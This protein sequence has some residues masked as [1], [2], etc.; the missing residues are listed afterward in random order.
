MVPIRIRQRIIGLVLN[1]HPILGMTL[2][3]LALGLLS[4]LIVSVIIFTAVSMLPGDFAS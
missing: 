3:R 4:L 1:S 2:R